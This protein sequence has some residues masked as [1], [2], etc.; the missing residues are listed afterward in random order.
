M[1]FF[2]Q[3]PDSC[4]PP[5]SLRQD[6]SVNIP[7]LIPLDYL[8]VMKVETTTLSNAIFCSDL[9]FHALTHL[10]HSRDNGSCL[11]FCI[12]LN[13]RP[14]NLAPRA[15]MCWVKSICNGVRM[16]C[17]NPKGCSQ[18]KPQISPD[19]HCKS[20]GEAYRTPQDGIS[21]SK[22]A[23]TGRRNMASYFSILWEEQPTLFY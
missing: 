22:A 19:N 6:C 5:S 7:I 3:S 1:P 4:T 12:G 10:T 14:Y 18:K 11:F 9:V 23:G 8:L 13:R 16:P 15:F 20:I 17:N 2:T 21:N